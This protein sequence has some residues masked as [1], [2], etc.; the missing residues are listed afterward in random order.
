MKIGI[1]SFQGAVIE[2]IRH[3]E[4]LGHEPIEVK[5]IEQLDSL[6]GIILPRGESTTIGKLLNRDGKMAALRARIEQGK[7]VGGTS[8]GMILLAKEIRDDS[9]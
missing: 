6:D 7:P 9:L 2:H 1:L 5:Y 8:A 4:A 3:I